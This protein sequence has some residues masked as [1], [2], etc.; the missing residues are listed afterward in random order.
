MNDCDA[1]VIGAGISGLA[2][3]TALAQAGL[4]VTVWERNAAAG[5]KIDSERLNGYL[6][7]RGAS[8]LMNFRPD[9][10]RFLH[11][12]GL[13]ALKAPRAVAAGQRRYVLDDGRLRSVPLTVSGLLLSSL[14]SWRGKLR[15]LAE[16]LQPRRLDTGESVAAF[17]RRRFGS[18]LLAKAMEP[19][20]AGTLASDAEHANAHSVLPRLTALEQRYGSITGGVVVNKLLRRRTAMT[21]EVFSFAGGMR[22]LIAH[23]AANP[24]LHFQGGHQVVEIAPALG[25]WRVSAS[26]ASGERS[27]IARHVV[28]CSP[29]PVAAALLRAFDPA[30]A[31]LLAGIA[32]A[33]LNVVHLGFDR[34]TIG[35]RLDGVGF[36]APAQAGLRITGS[37]WIS[38][39]FPDRAPPG[40]VL[41][42]NYLGGCRR[43]Q[44]IDW[45]DDAC[46]DAVLADLQP[47]LGI[48]GGPTM[49]HVV[50]HREALPL[51][52]GD[53]HQRCASICRLGRR[54]PGLHLQANYLGGVSVR[55]RIGQGGALAARIVQDMGAAPAPAEVAAFHGLTVPA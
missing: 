6:L 17:V 18:E 15:L 30:R 39:L 8:L 37:Q 4:S 27:I 32:Y 29:A 50:R 54:W 24:A 14:W 1:L 11:A 41:L 13:H 44:A 49:A 45:S 19:F 12:S 36:L 21:P 22:G 55:D 51:Y 47:L 46:I 5:G 9:V 33:P 20:V 43:P 25:G 40:H 3:A 26:T 48:R 31:A 52:H 10:D 42:S 53:Y 7:E 38:S 34:E 23:L 35:H 2:T 16:P 28:L